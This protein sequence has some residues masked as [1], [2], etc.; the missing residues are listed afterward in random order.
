MKSKII[1]L[2]AVL[3]VT[4]LAF[5]GFGSAENLYEQRYS[6]QKPIPEFDTTKI[7][8]S[9][10][11]IAG[12]ATGNAKH[13]V[14][15]KAHTVLL[16]GTFG[17]DGFQSRLEALAET[18]G[19]HDV[20]IQIVANPCG[21][22]ALGCVM[23]LEH[24]VIQIAAE[25]QSYDDSELRSLLAHE[26][27]HTLQNRLPAYVVYAPNYLG[28]Y[29]YDLEWNADCMTIQLIGYTVSNYGY[30]CSDYQLKVAEEL[31]KLN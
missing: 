7:M 4:A 8:K 27:A 28:A 22:G 20:T 1:K 30:E 14:R 16:S 2:A 11:K 21:I 3:T 26:Y 19:A 23:A 6:Y 24:S 13:T 10:D 15:M 5:W 9:I 17:T 12:A 31:W 29:E 25:T 18:V